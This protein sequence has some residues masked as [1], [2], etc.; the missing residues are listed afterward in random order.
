MAGRSATRIWPLSPECWIIAGALWPCGPHL[1][2]PLN[3]SHFARYRWLLVWL[4]G[5]RTVI[6]SVAAGPITGVGW[7]RSTKRSIWHYG[8]SNLS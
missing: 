4:G 8:C 7:T 3:I 1:L 6:F 5:L 2:L